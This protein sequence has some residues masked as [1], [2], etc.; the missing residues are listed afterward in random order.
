MFSEVSGRLISDSLLLFGRSTHTLCH[1]QHLS[2]HP[3]R[4]SRLPHQCP[5]HH[6]LHPLQR[7]HLSLH[8]HRCLCR[9]QPQLRHQHQHQLLHRPLKRCR[10]L[11][12]HSQVWTCCSP[13]V[14]LGSVRGCDMEARLKTRLSC[15]KGP[16]PDAVHRFVCF[17]CTAVAAVRCR[18]VNSLNLW[19]YF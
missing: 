16:P 5:H 2:P 14:V 6:H 15:P 18:A 4:R 8:P 17:G 10:Y 1:K 7:H 3:R 9:S 12:L 13:C 11:P 19:C